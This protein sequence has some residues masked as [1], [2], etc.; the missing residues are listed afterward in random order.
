MSHA[1]QTASAAVTTSSFGGN[2][3]DIVNAVTVDAA[4][5]LFIARRTSSRDLPGVDRAY[6]RQLY[7]W[8]G[9]DGFFGPTDAFVAKLDPGDRVVWSTYLGGND[10]RLSRFGRPIEEVRAIAVD[11]AGNVYVAG[12]TGS[13]NF[14]TVNAFQPSALSTGTGASD[15]FV[16]KLNATGSEMLFSTYVGGSDASSSVDAIALGPDGDV[17]IAAQSAAVGS[18][19]TVS[20][21]AHTTGVSGSAPTTVSR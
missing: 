5:N 6:Q 16:A 21:S 20:P 15:G 14:P 11:A 17:W 18:E 13:T 9:P 12:I 7:G 8:Q 4:G 19:S 3:L 10:A 1:R 2:G